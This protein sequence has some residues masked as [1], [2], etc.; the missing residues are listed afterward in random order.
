MPGGLKRYYGFGGL[1]FTTCSCYQRQPRLGSPGKR[2]ALL[3][4]LEQVRRKYR[5][6][7]F[8][9]VVMPEH[10]HT[11][12]GEPEIG[13]PSTVM[14]VL[15]ETVAQKLLPYRRRRQQNEVACEGA[16]NERHFWQP[17]FYDFNVFTWAKLTEKLRYM[18]RNPVKQGLVPKPELWPRNSYRAHAFGEEGLVKI[19]CLNPRNPRNRGQSPVFYRQLTLIL[20]FGAVVSCATTAPC[21]VCKSS[22]S[23]EA[24]YREASDIFVGEVIASNRFSSSYFLR[25]EKV[26]KGHAVSQ[27]RVLSGYSDE[28]LLRLGER[29]LIYGNRLS[30]S[31]P[32]RISACGRTRPLSQAGPDIKYLSAQVRQK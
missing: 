3:R 26:F 25:V 10:F 9:Y 6:E 5:F 2:E 20:V 16:A 22:T 11:L 7:V 27:I 14:Q 13:N 29:Y 15:K 12:I 31:A 23:M 24:S 28:Y 21:T 17:R 19:E 8:G 30:E 32:L 4:M 1:H 18:H